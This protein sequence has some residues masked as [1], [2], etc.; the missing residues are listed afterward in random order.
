MQTI[1][2]DLSERLKDLNAGMEPVELAGTAEAPQ[3]GHFSGSITG[4]TDV[5]GD[6]V[7]AN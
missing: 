1:T 6:P 4:W 5:T 7:E 2:S 3:D